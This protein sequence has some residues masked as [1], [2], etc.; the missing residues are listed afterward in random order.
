MIK[1][2]LVFILGLSI[3]A[4]GSMSKMVHYED[5]TIRETAKETIDPLDQPSV[6]KIDVGAPL[7]SLIIKERLGKITIG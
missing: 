2:T 7:N 3:S 5:Q 1:A 6:Q 4:C